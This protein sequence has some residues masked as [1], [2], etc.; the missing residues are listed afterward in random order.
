MKK[1]LDNFSD[2]PF[3]KKDVV[4]LLACYNVGFFVFW[5]LSLGSFKE[6]F[7]I[8]LFVSL[9]TMVFITISHLFEKKDEEETKFHNTMH[10]LSQRIREEYKKIY[11]LKCRNELLAKTGCLKPEERKNVICD[12][13]IS[14]E[15]IP[16]DFEKVNKVHFNY[17]SEFRNS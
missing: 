9:L 13:D 16:E 14:Q 8:A 10:K 1:I 6:C 2:F 3:N 12:I 15:K 11:R 4:I 17:R 5:R 7:L